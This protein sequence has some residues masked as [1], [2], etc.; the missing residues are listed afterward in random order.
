M[1]C[2]VSISA[3]DTPRA[4]ETVF[5]SH[6]GAIKDFALNTADNELAAAIVVE[7]EIKVCAAVMV[8]GM[9]APVIPGAIC[10]K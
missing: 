10:L 3:S 2:P 8:G 4:L 5:A 9:G 1:P 6:P 7:G